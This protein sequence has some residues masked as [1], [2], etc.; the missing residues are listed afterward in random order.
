MVLPENITDKSEEDE[1]LDPEDSLEFYKY[2][3]TNGIKA[4]N[5]TD[6]KL[7][8]KLIERR[9]GDELWLGVFLFIQ[10]GMVSMYWSLLSRFLYVKL[11]SRKA[12]TPK[13]AKDQK[14]M[15]IHIK[16]VSEDFQFEYDGDAKTFMKIIKELNK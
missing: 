8:G 10:S 9:G 4:A 6:L 15:G 3:K 16:I 1:L 11:Q 5:S 14:D 7:N 2:L 12:L 13:D